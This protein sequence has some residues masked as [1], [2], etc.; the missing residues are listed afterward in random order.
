LV[1]FLGAASS[2]LESE[3][4][5]VDAALLFRFLFLF[6]CVGG[7]VAAADGIIVG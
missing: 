3:D 7:F 2:V 5:L 6:L 4:E 1:A